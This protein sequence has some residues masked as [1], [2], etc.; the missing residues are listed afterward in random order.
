MRDLSA[1]FSAVKEEFKSAL[2]KSIVEATD[3]YISVVDNALE[4]PKNSE[5]GDLAFPC[6]LL[7]K[8]WK[9]PPPKCA[10]KLAAEIKLPQCFSSLTPTGPF[11]NFRYNTAYLAGKVL[12]RYCTLL[13]TGLPESGAGQTVVIEYSSPN[14]AKP[15]HVGHLRATLIGNA[16]DRI[17]RFSGHKTACTCC[18][19]SYQPCQ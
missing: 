9:L 18:F 5:F 10:E 16:L 4:K 15:F 13:S 3:L 17:Y 14:I 11:L 6:F 8:S 19:T 2:V 1:G 12:D 7:A